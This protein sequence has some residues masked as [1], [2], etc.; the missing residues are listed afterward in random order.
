MLS[1][2]PIRLPKS[3]QAVQ[4]RTHMDNHPDH[5]EARTSLSFHIARHSYGV[6]EKTRLITHCC[7]FLPTGGR[8]CSLLFVPRCLRHAYRAWSSPS[9]LS[10][11]WNC[12]ERVTTGEGFPVFSSETFLYTCG[13]GV[14]GKPFRV[15]S[16]DTASSA[17]ADGRGCHP[18]K[19]A[20]L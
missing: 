6:D 19:H 2:P 3:G 12:G 15:R 14:E 17:L 16:R 4:L 7:L 1:Q 10:G 13:N 9:E 18:T 11:R 5:S 20:D 8:K